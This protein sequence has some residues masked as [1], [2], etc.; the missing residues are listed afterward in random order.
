MVLIKVLLLPFTICVA[1]LFL[2]AIAIGFYFEDDTT[3]WGM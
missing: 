3:E 2:V 1:A